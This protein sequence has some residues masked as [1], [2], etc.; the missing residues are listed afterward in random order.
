MVRKV[1]LRVVFPLRTWLVLQSVSG[2]RKLRAQSPG[3]NASN[4]Y[5]VEAVAEVVESTEVE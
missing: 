4:A 2:I 3:S 5:T 1:V